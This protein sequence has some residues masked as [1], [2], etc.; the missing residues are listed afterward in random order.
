MRQVR[1]TKVSRTRS[2]RRQSLLDELPLDPRDPD[3]VKA[4]ARPDVPADDPH[5]VLPG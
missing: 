2:Q 3:I 5:E 4:K 1:V